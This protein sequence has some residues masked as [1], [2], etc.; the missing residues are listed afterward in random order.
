MSKLNRPQLLAAPGSTW[1]HLAN[2]S[3]AWPTP[4]QR[5]KMPMFCCAPTAI[6][7]L[8]NIFTGVWERGGGAHEFGVGGDVTMS[9]SAMLARLGDCVI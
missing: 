1:Q 6:R 4:G 3:N 2:P 8:L 7:I 9:S 5:L